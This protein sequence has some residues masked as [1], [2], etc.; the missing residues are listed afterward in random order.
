VKQDR[1]PGIVAVAEIVEWSSAQERG[2]RTGAVNERV[3]SFEGGSAITIQRKENVGTVF[4]DL[5]VA[6][7]FFV[8]LG[9]K[10]LGESTACNCTRGASSAT[11]LMFIHT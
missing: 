5:A 7:A 6:T 8:E 4:D 2:S 3:G 1:A 10:V 9:L 11:L